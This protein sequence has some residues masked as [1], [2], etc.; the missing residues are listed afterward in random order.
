MEQ[1]RD[2]D[3]RAFE[4]LYQ[5]VAVPLF[6]FIQFRVPRKEDAEDILQNVLIK[7]YGALPSYTD[8]GVAPLSFFY[9]VARN[10]VIDFQR[11]KHDV[12]DEHIIQHADL[13]QDETDIALESEKTEESEK[14]HRALLELSS[15]QRDV[16]TLK[17]L[18]DLT[19]AEIAVIL[20][21][22]EV[23]VRQLQSRGLHALRTILDASHD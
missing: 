22:S 23:G 13:L 16:I 6:R 2:G 19:Y 4:L 3:E 12:L 15:D 9:A 1:A 17:F 14:I 18:H 20:N 21:K 11:K 7:V 8:R 5:Q 10:A